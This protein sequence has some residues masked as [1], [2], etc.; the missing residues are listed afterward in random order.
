MSR[1]EPVSH[2][3]ATLN[4]LFFLGIPRGAALAIVLGVLVCPQIACLIPQDI[5]A[6]TD[7][8]GAVP[9]FLPES[10][11]SYLLPPILTLI[12]QGAADAALT[13]PCHCQLQF[14]GLV[15]QA[16]PT[17]TLEARWFV[18]YDTTN[19]SSTRPFQ[20]DDYPPIFN[21]VTQTTRTLN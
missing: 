3:S 4:R 12:R 20:S 2:L 1:R 19:P 17:L 14:D 10:F 18:D 9:A 5:E 6:K 16:D 8:P 21:D 15:I 7:T 11:P 13:P